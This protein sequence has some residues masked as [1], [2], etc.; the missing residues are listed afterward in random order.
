MLQL[1]FP[2]LS[3]W[4]ANSRGRYIAEYSE[5][6]K[7]K[8]SGKAMGIHLLPE[9]KDRA[10]VQH[11]DASMRPRGTFF[12]CI[13]QTCRNVKPPHDSLH[14]SLFTF[15]LWLVPFMPTVGF[16]RQAWANT[17]AVR[18]PYPPFSQLQ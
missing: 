3:S 1:Q 18:A 11:Q 16:C 7:G 14:L 5:P 4:I 13:T 9:L 6:E 8:P 2:S 10:A 12:F 15:L 17:R